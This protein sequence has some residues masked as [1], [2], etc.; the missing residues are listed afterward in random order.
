MPSL[1]RD[2]AALERH[3]FDVI[4]VGGGI[5]GACV[6]HDAALRG[7]SVALLEKADFGAATSAASS[8]LIHTGVRYLQ[9]GRFDKVRESAREQQIFRQIAAPFGHDLP[10]LIPTYPGLTKGRHLVGAGLALY[11]LICLDLRRE[12]EGEPRRL[13]DGFIG[14]DALVARVPVL[15]G[16]PSV[17]GAWVV[18]ERHLFSTERVTLAFLKTAAGNGARL[19]NYLEATALR[20][21]AGRI[22]RLVA[23]DR[24]TGREVELAGRVVVNAAGPWIPALLG[25]FGA[26]Q[27]AKPVTAFAKGMHLVTRRLLDDVALAL[28]TVQPGRGIVTRGGRHIFILPWRGHS[29]IGTT[30]VP[31]RGTP[32]EITVE[33]REIAEFLDE[34]TAAL[35]GAGLR[36]EDVCYAYAGLYPLTDPVVRPGVFQG[37][38]DYQ[39]VD[40]ASRGGPEG[41]VTVLGARYTT[42][43]H[44]ASRAVDLVARRLGRSAPCTTDTVPLFGARPLGD[45]APP[46]R[47]SRMVDAPTMAYL[48]SHYGYEAEAL[49]ARLER[50]PHLARRISPA[51]ETLAVE[52]AHAVEHEMAVHL[53]DV[54]FRRTG[55]GTLGDPGEAC[56]RACAD[57]MG[58]R[59]GWT[60]AERATEMR[61]TQATFPRIVMTGTS[62]PGA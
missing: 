29:L 44:V 9:Q 34:I 54:V 59:L 38:V 14:R 23:I 35:P 41:L 39:L 2:L 8:K 30:N 22:T 11:R 45:A 4:V 62:P 53:G 61:A 56:L 36:P 51:R 21:D 32:D 1:L 25:N 18:H 5:T 15:E 42:A 31:H 7:L 27:T 50:E 60:D 47:S 55:L 33:A 24:V 16:L 10:F 6:A 26:R 52:V 3:A 48:R 13:A 19:A 17:T 20:L 46:G 37:A 58:E 12:A 43:R 40:H 49:V 28:P 57:L